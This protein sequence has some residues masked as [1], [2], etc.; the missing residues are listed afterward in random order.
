MRH[1]EEH[2][3]VK[4]YPCCYELYDHSDSVSIDQD[5]VEEAWARA[6]E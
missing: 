5:P 6:I 3:K 4:I 1:L 2:Q